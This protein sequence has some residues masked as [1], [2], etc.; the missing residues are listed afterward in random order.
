M[1]PELVH[2]DKMNRTATGVDFMGRGMLMDMKN[3]SAAARGTMLELR[4]VNPLP[5][6]C[7]ACD[8]KQKL[9]NA[10]DEDEK[11][12]MELEEGFFF[13]CGCCEYGAERFY[14]AA[15]EEHMGDPSTQ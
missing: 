10:A 14:L 2:N 12:R 9:Y 3:T 5:A 4:E 7:Q 1:G 11:L 13:D 6:V 8:E 15:K